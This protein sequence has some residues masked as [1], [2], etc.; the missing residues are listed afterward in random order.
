MHHLAIVS[1]SKQINFDDVSTVAAAVSKQVARDFWPAWGVNATVQA[2]SRLESVP[3]DY[4]HVIL[5]DSENSGM[6]GYHADAHGQPLAVVE[7]AGNWSLTVSHEV[8]EMLADP[9]GNRIISARAPVNCMHPD[10]RAVVNISMGDRVD[11]LAEVCDPVQGDVGY[12]INGVPV[13]D[14]VTPAY[15]SS[16]SEQQECAH[17]SRIGAG[18][19][20]DGGYLSFRDPSSGRW[21]QIMRSGDQIS[22]HQVSM[23]TLLGFAATVLR[24]RMDNR[25][26]QMR[27]GPR[28]QQI[29]HLYA[30]C[31]KKCDQTRRHLDYLRATLGK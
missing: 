18:Q 7:V 1:E 2:F 13:S 19:I 27:K 5:V 22:A 16:S 26:K 21:F 24:E 9:F 3:S 20:E 30:R 6:A 28:L 17:I 10:V 14:F 31:A 25:A 15:Y 4:W 29:L 8:L 12:E 11:Y 23:N